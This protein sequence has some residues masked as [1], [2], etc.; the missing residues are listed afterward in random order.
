MIIFKT[1]F[2]GSTG[3]FHTCEDETT[4][5]AVDFGIVISKAKKAMDFKLTGLNGILSTHKH[6][7]HCKGLPSAIKAGI[8]CYTSKDVIDHLK[9]PGH[10]VHEIQLNKVF[11]IG[12]L[13]ILPFPLEHDVPNMG[14]IIKSTNGGKLV[15]I[16]DSYYCRFRFENVTIFAIECNYAENILDNNISSGA[17]SPS[18]RNR[19]VKSH[20]SLNNVKEFFK[21]NDLS[22]CEEIH[23]IHLSSS[24]ADPKRFKN[25]IQ[26]LTGKPTYI[27]GA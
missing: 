17:V 16:T 3:N 27:N 20:F 1:Y 11:K 2:T 6:M 9:I 7:D 12:S 22:K 4:K 21:A 25:E 8:D 15:Y 13:R 19:I 5:I 23:L 18:L 10:R 26:K 14:F 24:N